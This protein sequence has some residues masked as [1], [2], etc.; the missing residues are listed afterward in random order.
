M[1]KQIIN[2]SEVKNKD[3]IENE[4]ENISKI[5]KLTQLN[6]LGALCLAGNNNVKAISI[7]KK[8]I[9]FYE[10]SISE[11]EISKFFYG[12]L[13]CNYAK[14]L[15]V[16]KNF[17]QS[18]KYYIKVIDN[19]PVKDTL[20]ISFLKEE[21]EIDIFDLYTI[22]DITS[23]D[24]IKYHRK[25]M[26]NLEKEIFTSKFYNNSLNSVSTYSDA[27]VNLAVIFQI[28]HK[29]TLTSLKMFILSILTDK[30]NSVANI[31][32]NS[33]LRENNYKH[34]SDEYISKKIEIGLKKE[35]CG[36]IMINSYICNCNEWRNKGKKL[37]IRFFFICM[38]EMGK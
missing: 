33:F 31:D 16:D 11:G 25:L 34:L 1:E 3:I 14:A 26:D 4:S 20:N 2:E 12:N 30:N 35:Q 10:K 21:F 15:S 24:I 29:E 17:T 27:L 32:Y 19:H 6:K 23:D 37:I 28:K 7:L 8:T 38:H 13:Y 36:S 18:E 9:E 22:T 5:E